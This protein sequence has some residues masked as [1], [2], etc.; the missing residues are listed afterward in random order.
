[1]FTFT[2]S[3]TESSVFFIFIPEVRVVFFFSLVAS[4]LFALRVLVLQNYIVAI[5]EDTV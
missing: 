1:M 5:P 4:D 3:S 2:F